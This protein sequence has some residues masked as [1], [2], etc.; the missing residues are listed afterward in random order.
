MPIARSEAKKH[1]MK[2][3]HGI[4]SFSVLLSD[5]AAVVTGLSVVTGFSVVGSGAVN[6]KRKY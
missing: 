4:N 3:I 5:P 6:K 2:G 1:T